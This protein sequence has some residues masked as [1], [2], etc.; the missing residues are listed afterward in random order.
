MALP[1]ARSILLAWFSI[2]V[3]LQILNEQATYKKSKQTERVIYIVESVY[4]FAK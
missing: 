1:G 2:T 4:K 3:L